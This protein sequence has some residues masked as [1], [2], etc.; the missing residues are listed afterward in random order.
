MFDKEVTIIGAG[1]AGLTL[2]RILQI[3]GV[4][5]RIF[6]HDSSFSSRD[7]G[8]TFDIHDDGGQKALIAAKL[9]DEFKLLS[10]PEGNSTK[11][12]D[13]HGKIHYEDYGQPDDM[14]RPEIDRQVLRNLLL[15]ALE[16]NTVTWGKHVTSIESLDNGQHKITFKDGTSEVTDF[17]VG[18]D[19]TWSKVRSILT[20]IQPTYTGITFT[21]TRISN[22]E[23]TLPHIKDLVGE[24]N[25]NVLSDD[26]GI[27]A[28]K[29]GDQSIRIY[30]AARVPETFKEQ[31]DFSQYNVIRSM[32]LDVFSGWD[33]KLLDMINKSDDHFIPRL[34]YS[35][36][37]DEYWTTKFGV[38]II[39]DAAH[40]MTPF[41]GQGANL[42]MLDAL[43]LADLLTSK[44]FSNESTAE[45]NLKTFEQTMI[46]RARIFSDESFG[47]MNMFIAADAPKGATDFFKSMQPPE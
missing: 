23:A 24:G 45:A 39:G 16:P 2:A 29:N 28:Q 18:A 26:K 12:I 35:Q 44:D 25:I 19:G 40:V 21:E 17:L 34:I 33:E 30:A 20:P 36:N 7:Q 37:L 3:R 9:F 41:A 42:A 46:D 13:K 6:E 38:T 5:V 11:I 31:F 15:T 8:G 43:E 1:P 47:N 27:F 14:S 10:R 4:R 22:P 32:L